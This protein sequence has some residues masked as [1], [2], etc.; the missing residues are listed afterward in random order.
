MR[1][2]VPYFGG[3]QRIADRLVALLPEH[4][5]YV[6]P[7]AGG[8]SVLLAKPMSTLETVNDLDGDIVCFWRVL[9]DRPEELARAC[10]LTP[11]SRG[12][13]AAARERDDLDGHTTG[14]LERARR[15]WVCLTQGRGGQLM[16]TGWRYY[17]RPTQHM[18]LPGYLEAYVQ[19]MAAAASRLQHVSLECRPA[20]EVIDLYGAAA[21]VLLY[22]DPPYLASTRGGPGSTTAY[23][24]ELKTVDQHREL[25]EHL[26]QVKAAVVLSGYA[27]DLYDRDLFTDW[28]RVE[29]PAC[30]GNG[31][32]GRGLGAGTRTEVLWSNRPLAVQEALFEHTSA[33]CG[34]GTDTNNQ[35]T[36]EH[37]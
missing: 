25:A 32:H 36:S 6:E 33:L 29:I 21:D 37:S 31:N 20:L 22:V 15:V 17:V 28:D 5:H 9:R 4:K 30:T 18:G 23:R 2:P 34:A 3:K 24:H 7:F 1:P 14:E 8:L 12:E 16:K 13:L 35:E 10:A 27:S 11:H 26:H 19:R